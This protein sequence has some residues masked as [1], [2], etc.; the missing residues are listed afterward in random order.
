MTSFAL[1]ETPIGTCGI[2]WGDAGIMAVQLPEG[3]AA[4]TRARLL[5]RH[6]NA[7][8]SA[9]PD[10]IRATID[11][12]VALLAGESRDLASARL[13]ARNVAD[14]DRRVY[15]AAR[16]IRPG[17]TS[18]YGAL[19]A[20]LGDATL[21]RAIGQSLGK[22]PWPIIVPCHRVLGANGRLGGFSAN[23]GAE[24]KRRMLVIEGA[25]TDLFG[26]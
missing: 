20:Q 23:G 15:E 9:P 17:E 22:N 8:E 5:R 11:D 18:T 10:D 13:D 7:A 2:V 25:I 26:V 19:A 6:P 4:A 21:S 3:S 12:I 1:F 24:T 14:F 16:R